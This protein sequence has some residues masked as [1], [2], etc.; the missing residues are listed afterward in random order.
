MI[1]IDTQVMLWGIKKD[2]S[3]DRVC[4]ID[5]AVDFLKDMRNRN[6]RIVIPTQ[7]LQEFLVRYNESDRLAILTKLDRAFIVA[8][9]DGQA[10]VVAAKMKAD[11]VAWSKSRTETSTTKNCIS[12]DMI[13]LAT[14]IAHGA[15]RM[16]SEDDDLHNLATHL[17]LPI[18]VERLPVPP[19]ATKYL[20]GM[21]P[22]EGE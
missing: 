20:S 15:K 17:T 12:A 6:E 5:L 9:Y 19:P 11:K 4:M 10:A 21:Q 1:A 18:S 16:F 3:P 7:A 13:I 22:D 14:A 8:P 2:A